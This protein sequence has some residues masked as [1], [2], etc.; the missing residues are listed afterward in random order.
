MAWVLNGLELVVENAV[1][2]TDDESIAHNTFWLTDSK[3]R[4]L[5]QKRAELMAERLGDYITY[6]TPDDKV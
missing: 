4:K 5:K 2:T 3:G 1:L 6:C